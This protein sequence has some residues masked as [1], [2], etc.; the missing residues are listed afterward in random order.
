[1]ILHFRISSQSAGRAGLKDVTSSEARNKTKTHSLKDGFQFLD[2][3]QDTHCCKNFYL[4][5]VN[6]CLLEKVISELS[7]VY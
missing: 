5:T 7:K 4:L 2:M 3:L 6:N 1:M